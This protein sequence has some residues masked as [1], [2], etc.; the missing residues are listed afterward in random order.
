MYLN[1]VQQLVTNFIRHKDRVEK[2][3]KMFQKIINEDNQMLKD[4]VIQISKI[5]KDDINKI[6][7]DDVVSLPELEEFKS[8]V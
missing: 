3:V 1:A 6:A 4:G 5:F 2:R 7:N 8:E